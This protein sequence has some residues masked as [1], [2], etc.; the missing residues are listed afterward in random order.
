[1][2]GLRNIFYIFDIY[3]VIVKVI[4]REKFEFEDSLLVDYGSFLLTENKFVNNIDLYFY[5]GMN[6]PFMKKG[7]L[8]LCG[9]TVNITDNKYEFN[10]NELSNE[11]F[12]VNDFRPYFTTAIYYLLFKTNN[13]ILIHSSCV[14]YEDDVILFVG[15]SGSG[16]SS[17]ALKSILEGAKYFSNDLTFLHSKNGEIIASAMPQEMNI[18]EQAYNWFKTNVSNFDD[19]CSNK[20]I[21]YAHKKKKICIHPNKLIKG[22]T[23]QGTVRMIIFPEPVLS[24]ENHPFFEKVDRNVAFRKLLTQVQPM[25]KKG[26][27][28]FIE[29]HNFINVINNIFENDNNVNYYNLYWCK[30]H[31]ANFELLLE[32][33]NK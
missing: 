20:F 23:M 24:S 31:N 22:N 6:E 1:M 18:G 33:L 19:F 17:L 14:Q 13:N 15:E 30:N 29:K 25:S 5:V 10:G 4:T 3:G 16:K 12:Y 9:N 32:L 21:K 26:F 11:N 2:K 28:P 27:S 7:I 8:S